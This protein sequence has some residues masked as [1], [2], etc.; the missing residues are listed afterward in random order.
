MIQSSKEY[1]YY[2]ECDRIALGKVRKRPSLFG[3]EIWKFE[4]CMRRLA[5]L[6]ASPSIF[7]IIPRLLTKSKYHHLSVKLGFTIPYNVCG[8]G[9]AIVHYGTIIISNNTIIGKNCRIHAEI[10]IGTSGGSTKAPQLGDNVYIGPGAKL[11]GDITIGN[12]VCIGANAV[13]VKDVEDGIT[14]GG[15]PAKK[16]SN[17]DSTRHLVKATEIVVFKSNGETK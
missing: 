5:Y 1:K 9:L 15:V 14:V 10:N 11:V 4:R 2:L 3:D 7:C 17:H 13:V 16:I 12:D 6:S 8:P